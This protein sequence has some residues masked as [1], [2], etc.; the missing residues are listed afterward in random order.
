MEKKTKII[1]SN[2]HNISI[3][4]VFLA[5]FGFKLAIFTFVDYGFGLGGS[6]GFART[7]KIRCFRKEFKSFLLLNV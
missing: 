7:K 3:E 2:N 1:F 4:N 5:V 6:G